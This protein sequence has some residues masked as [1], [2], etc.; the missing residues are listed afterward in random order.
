MEVVIM[1]TNENS[2]K[3]GHPVLALVLGIIGIVAALPI[4]MLG[5]IIGGAIAGAF[6]LAALLIGISSRKYGKGMGGIV[7]GVIAILL[8]VTL[9]SAFVNVYRDLQKKAEEAS[10]VAPLMSKYLNKPEL[11]FVG[12]LL[13]IPKDEASLDALS[14]ELDA[15]R[16][17]ESSDT[18]ATAVPTETA[19]PAETAAPAPSPAQ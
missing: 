10:D 17:L 11:G 13:N 5:C 12:L 15:L 2:Y 16:K 7:T 6:G 4:C 8:A 19:V 9:T 18:A 3:S 14:K 1:S